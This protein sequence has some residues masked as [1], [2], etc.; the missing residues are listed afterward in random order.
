MFENVDGASPTN[1]QKRK[2]EPNVNRHPV[3]PKFIKIV[4][5]NDTKL[6]EILRRKVKLNQPY[7]GIFVKKSDDN[8]DEVVKNVDD[9]YPVGTFAQIVELQDL[10]TR[11]RMVLMAHRRIRINEQFCEESELPLSVLTDDKGEAGVIEEEPKADKMKPSDDRLFIGKTE[12]VVHKEFETTEEVKAMTQEV[13]KTIR[14]IISLNPLYRDSLQQM[15][16]YGQR[17]VDNPVYL[18]DLG[19]ALTGGETGDLM[20]VLEE[21]N[22]P[23]RLMLSLKLL[24]KE[25]E[26]S[27]LQQKIGKEV[28]KIK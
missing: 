25:Y 19:A 23:T 8:T 20:S 6:I 16:Q 3:F 28:N 13:I 26:L 10:G 1:P 15:L 27:K 22:I 24:K 17:V 11:V 18:S 5:V 9:L 12:N 2:P 14:D 7:A 21:E 4:E